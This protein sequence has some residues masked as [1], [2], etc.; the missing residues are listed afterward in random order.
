MSHPAHHR[1]WHLL[2][3]SLL[4]VPLAFAGL[5]VY[6]HAPDYY[7]GHL[8]VNLAVIG[9]ILLVLRLVDAVQDPFI[10]AISDQLHRH[11]P[12]ILVVG[13][14][15]MAGGFWML[16]H[17]VR[18]QLLLWFTISGLLCTTGFSIVSINYMA[19]GGLWVSTPAER[20]RVTGWREG[21]GLIGLLL[22]ALA[23]SLLMRDTNPDLAFHQLTLL[24][25]PLL[26]LGAVLM[27][28][29]MARAHIS[30]P[31]V[32]FR[33][34]RPVLMRVI[35]SRWN[36]W[37]FG[38]YLGNS[39]A[40]TI[41]AVLVLFFVRDRIEAPQLIGLFLL[42]YFLS[43]ALSM[44]AVRWISERIGK[45]STWLGSMWLAVGTFGWAAML[46]S[47]DVVMYGI[48]CALSGL[49]L[50]ADLSLPPSMLADRIAERRD[51][52]AAAS[53]FAALAFLTKSALA[54]ATGL[55]LPLLGALGYQPGAVDDY[56]VTRHL[57][58]A[59]AVIPCM[60]KVA[61]A[62]WLWRFVRWSR[63]QAADGKV[64]I[65]HELARAS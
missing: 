54:L 11:R 52:D 27:F 51:E 14:A 36:R 39:M 44:P 47:G 25:L 16:F 50:G 6:L 59:Y 18:E 20:T 33:R 17:P 29:W 23:P 43:G 12:A 46:G 61:T 8:G 48:V 2:Q 13:L 56:A 10:G 28:R 24:Y 49:A 7:A 26:A 53:Y 55:T 15:L 31:R 19:L 60:L 38:V 42:L 21:A 22:A 57:V 34:L 32:E 30:Q 58:V 65:P 35:D 3:Y 63:Q 41:P 9:L 40:G 1:R 4:A 45:G 64:R 62:L 37:F 5:P